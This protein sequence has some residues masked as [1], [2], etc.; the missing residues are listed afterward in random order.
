ML[1]EPRNVL[2]HF[3]D[4]AIRATHPDRV[5]PPQLPDPPAGRTIVIGWGKA[6]AAMARAAEA[7]WPGPLDGLVVTR[8]GYGVACERI[9]VIEAAHPVPDAAG[10]EAARRILDLARSAGP[11]DLVIAVVS[12]G[13]S[14][15]L[16][17]P[18]PGVSLEDKRALTKALLRS[19][20]EI[21]EIN[22]V[23]RHLSAVKGGR[24]AEAVAPAKLVSLII[25][26]VVGDDPA[27]VAS[28]ATVPDP[29]TTADALAVLA[30]YRIDT[31]ATVLDF[32]ASPQSETPK[33]GDPAFSCAE[34]V[35]V[36]RAADALGAAA[37]EARRLGINPVILG[38]DVTGEARDVGRA[39]GE[40]VLARA[41]T[42]GPEVLFSAGECTVTLAGEG[43]GGPNLEYLMGLALALDGEPGVAALAADTDGIDGSEDN[44]GGFI[45]PSTLVRAARQGL[46]PACYLAQNDSYAFFEEID[47]LLVTGPTYTNVNDFR[48]ILIE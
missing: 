45:T 2:R 8:Y 33:P 11:D 14:A 43:R 16:S 17:L 26:D 18:A 32:L 12:G 27:D 5:V 39:H 1:N 42:G 13:G 47:D 24:L 40:A 28:G 3:F 22:T 44:A 23:R 41:G 19:G 48:A 10:R 36:A 9:R 35:I 20:A 46:D 34:A 37:G 21:R 6:S 30:K 31:P 38:D 4:T 25:S 15:L 29:T 7:N